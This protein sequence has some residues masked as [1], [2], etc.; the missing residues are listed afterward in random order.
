MAKGRIVVDEEA[1]KG[2]ELCLPMCPTGLIQMADYYNT[3]GY[4]PARLVDPHHR[5]TGCT[6]CATICPDAAITVFREVKVRS[7]NGQS[8]ADTRLSAAA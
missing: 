2:C 7:Q 1:C 4:R 6:L 8:D 5:C 3:K